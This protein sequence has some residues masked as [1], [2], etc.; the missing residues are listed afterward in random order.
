MTHRAKTVLE[1]HSRC[2]TPWD[3]ACACPACIRDRAEYIKKQRRK[4]KELKE[5]YGKEDR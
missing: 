3:C 2:P 5:L 4:A 1:S